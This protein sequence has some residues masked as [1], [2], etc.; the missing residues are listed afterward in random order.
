[1]TI[2]F[3]LVAFAGA[4]L[5]TFRSLVWGFLDVL[6]LRYFNGV[7]PANS[8][9]IFRTF[10]LRPSLCWIARHGSSWVDC[11]PDGPTCLD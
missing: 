9:Q 11:L 1:M 2:V 4:L 8:P 7:I 5:A 3:L 10:N 6:A